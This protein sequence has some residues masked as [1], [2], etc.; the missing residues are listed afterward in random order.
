MQPKPA[1]LL[2]ASTNMLELLSGATIYTHWNARVASDFPFAR[3]VFFPDLTVGGWFPVAASSWPP[4]RLHREISPIRINPQREWFR[5]VRG[6][7]DI[8]AP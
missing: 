1:R 4:L 3:R 8:E 6:G 7:W 2:V 5:T